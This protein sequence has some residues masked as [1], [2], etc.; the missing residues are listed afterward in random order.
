LDK[1]PGT[2][3]YLLNSTESEGKFRQK[4]AMWAVEQLMKEGEQI[5]DWKV[6]KKAG[7]RPEDASEGYFEAN[8]IFMKTS[9]D[10]SGWIF[11]TRRF[12]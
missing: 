7:I 11:I 12:A 8:Q 5:H 2:K 4:K 3:A 1:F 10:C 9:T 6:L